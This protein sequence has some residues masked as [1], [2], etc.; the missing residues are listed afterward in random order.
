MVDFMT[1]LLC[2]IDSYMKE[3]SAKITA[4]EGKSIVLDKTAFYPHGGGQ[5]SDVGKILFNGKEHK[6]IS[7]KKAGANVL[8]EL[9]SIDGLHV[10]AVVHGVIDWHC[11]YKLMRFHTSA[12]IL[13][14][15]I[16]R[17]TGKLITGNQLDETYSRMDFDVENYSQEFLKVPELVRLKDIM[18]PAI[19]VW[20][21]VKIGD[22]DIQADG[23]THVKNT[24]E[25]GK[26]HITKTE[27]KGKSNR[28]VYWELI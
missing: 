13:A 8:H 4:I 1:E 22:L 19:S 2:L 6:V 12:H 21:I 20:R 3:F 18:P 17:E 10:G 16:F 27:N 14:A 9:D 26:I 11:C 15:V 23:G 5:P 7:V 25:I 28:R 24:S